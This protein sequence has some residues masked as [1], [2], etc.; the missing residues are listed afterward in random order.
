M[1]KTK[2]K[3]FRAPKPKPTGLPSVK[4]CEKEFEEGLLVEQSASCSN[5]SVDESTLNILEKLGSPNEEDREWGCTSVASLVSQ[6]ANISVLLENNVVKILGPLILDNSLQVRHKA[7]G[8]LRNLSVDGGVEACEEMIRRDILTPL[9]ALF[10]QYGQ[11][12]LPEQP[13]GK[14]KVH[15]ASEE[16]VNTFNKENLISYLWPC[17]QHS[18]YGL[19][20]AITV[21]QCLHTVTEDNNELKNVCKER[22]LTELQSLMSAPTDTP[23]LVL[24]KTLHTGIV[25]NLYGTELSTAPGNVVS[26]II[27]SVSDVLAI[28]AVS[29]LQSS[30][31][32]L[33][34]DIKR[35]LEGGQ[36]EQK[37]KVLM[38][39]EN[40]NFS[41]KASNIKNI[42]AAQQV[43][44]EIITNLCCSDDDEWEDMNSSESSSDEINQD[45]EMEDEPCVNN[46]ISPLCVPSEIHSAIVK[47]DIFTKVLNKS[48]PLDMTQLN[49]ASFEKQL[50][51]SD[52]YKSFDR[53]QNHGLLCINNLV[54]SMEPDDLGGIDNLHNKPSKLEAVTSALRA[55]VQKLA[56]LES[57]N[58]V[59]GNSQ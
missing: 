2:Q 50:T 29:A 11:G 45:I 25:V 27:S 46:F 18:V 5:G 24:L 44:L 26:A 13:T 40:N 9:V 7:L 30:I 32:E 21:V 54:S 17:L 8:A 51:K 53:L 58:A 59:I 19:P 57:P 48:Q 49:F 10:Q 23:E 47:N 41:E 38:E 42:L 3:K 22:A 39:T 56:E 28:D 4:D 52:I 6:P 36:T 12:W 35:S 1:G 20:L 15:E 37:E 33:Q 14:R 43:S 34:E 16:A 31:N 55:V